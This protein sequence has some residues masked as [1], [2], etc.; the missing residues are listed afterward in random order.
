[1]NITINDDSHKKIIGVL[2]ILLTFTFAVSVV[3][4]GADPFGFCEGLEDYCLDRSTG[5][6]GQSVGLVSLVLF[7]VLTPQLFMRSQIFYSWIKFAIPAIILGFIWML[8]RPIYPMGGGIGVLGHGPG[9]S[10]ESATMIFGVLFFLVSIIIIIFKAIKNKRM[11]KN[12]QNGFAPILILLIMLGGGYYVV[13][14]KS[15]VNMS[16]PVVAT[17]TTQTP[18]KH[19]PNAYAQAHVVLPVATVMKNTNMNVAEL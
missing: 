14:K 4:V 7:V 5:E 10:R 13:S 2:M 3:V 19:S 18:V 9:A 16:P 15:Q 1:M 6:I 12:L 17:S 11:M 8:G